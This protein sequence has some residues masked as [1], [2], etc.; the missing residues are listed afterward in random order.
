M[1]SKGEVMHCT[2]FELYK[3]ATSCLSCFCCSHAHC[4]V[5]SWI[6]LF[7]PGSVRNLVVGSF[8]YRRFISYCCYCYCTCYYRQ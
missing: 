4:S 2:A 5:A 3:V 7:I 1:A 8:F 6:S